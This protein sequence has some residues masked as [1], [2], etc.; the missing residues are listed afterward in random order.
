[1]SRENAAR[2][3]TPEELHPTTMALTAQVDYETGTSEKGS[4]RQVEEYHV[5]PNDLRS[6]PVGVAAVLSRVSSRRNIVRVQRTV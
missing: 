2:A 1:V 4:V 3:V 6:L 5:H